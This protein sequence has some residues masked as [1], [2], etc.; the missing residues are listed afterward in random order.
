MN[1]RLQ[2]LFETLDEYWGKAEVV[3]MVNNGYDLKALGKFYTENIANEATLTAD[4]LNIYLADK[5][6]IE[7]IDMLQF[8]RYKLLTEQNTAQT[9]FHID[10]RIEKYNTDY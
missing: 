10:K 1:K 3:Y 9:T 5:S 7:K 2:S 6:N 8:M 4:A